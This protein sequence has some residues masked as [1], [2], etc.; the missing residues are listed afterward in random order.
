MAT[1]GLATLRLMVPATS[2]GDTLEWLLPLE[3]DAP[4]DAACWYIDGSL[5]DERKRFGRRTGFGI[6]V[7]SA[8]GSLLAIGR[9]VPPSWVPDAAGAEVWAF[10]VA[11]RSQLQMPRV[12]TDCLG[13]LRCLQAGYKRAVGPSCRQARLWKIIG[14]ALDEEFANAAAAVK[15]MPYHLA[16]H[17]FNLARHS[18]GDPVTPV[19]WRANRLAD[20]LA[21]SAAEADRL[22][23]WVMRKVAD[24]GKLVVHHAARLGVATTRANNHSVTVTDE[25]GVS[26]TRVIR[27]STAE[28][29]NWKLRTRAQPSLCEQTGQGLA[30]TVSPT[31]P[32]HQPVAHEATKQPCAHGRK[33]RQQQP[34][35]PRA[36]KRARQSIVAAVRETCVTRSG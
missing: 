1:R 21:K 36:A 27:D 28:R 32:W 33:R 26:R 22:P 8:S 15:W 35:Q 13:I 23:K 12:V 2:P 11:I 7:V 18:G 16:A 25:H 19:M 14:L 29:P 34:L 30:T 9:G 10:L 17:T 6:V 31:L 4:E 3:S 24:M 20:L 5:F